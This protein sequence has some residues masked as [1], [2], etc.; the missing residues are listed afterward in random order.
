V[1]RA[2]LL[3][4]LAA[5]ACGSRGTGPGT[6]APDVDA[7]DGE[8]WLYR[9]LSTGLVRR[10]STLDTYRLVLDGERATLEVTNAT[11]GG[12]LPSRVADWHETSVRTFLG[13][14]TLDGDERL[15]EL[16]EAGTELVW[17]WSCTPHTY[18]VAPADA[19]REATPDGL[20]CGDPGRWSKPT[21]PTA[22]LACGDLAA[23]DPE[24]LEGIFAFAPAPGVEHLVVDDDC[25]S[26][27]GLRAIAP[28]GALAPV[29]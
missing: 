29:R 21:R 18:D 11:S 9:D 5:G 13:S 10:S 1:H 7:V 15:L 4:V 17:R 2:S 8:V 26:G 23:A 19:V 6:A 20:E 27:D 14:V 24:Q 22:I 12:E 28:G 25:V 3:L 16:R